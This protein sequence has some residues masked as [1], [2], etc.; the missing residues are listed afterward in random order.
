[1][2]LISQMK[3]GMNE[4]EQPM[5]CI[6]QSDT[7]DLCWNSFVFGKRKALLTQKAVII[8]ATTLVISV[9]GS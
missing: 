5:H 6:G 9:I 4:A 8:F 3:K 2:F 7:K 1:M